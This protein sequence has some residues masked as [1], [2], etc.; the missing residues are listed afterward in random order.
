[1]RSIVIEAGVSGVLAL[2]QL[3]SWGLNQDVLEGISESDKNLLTLGRVINEE[4]GGY[5][6]VTKYGVK[7]AKVSGKY[8]FACLVDTDYPTVGDWVLC[9][10]EDALLIDRLVDRT[11]LFC[12]RKSGTSNESQSIAANLDIVFIVTSVNSDFNL[13]R[14]E[15]YL[16]LVR[17]GG[18][19]PVIVLNKSD[20][21]VAQDSLTALAKVAPGVLT[22]SVSGLTGENMTQMLEVVSGGKTAALVGSSGVGKS[23]IL[24][25]LLGK[26]TQQVQDIRSED[27]RGRHTTTSRSMFLLPGGGILIDT[28]GVREVGMTDGEEGVKETFADL[29]LMALDCRFSNCGHESEPGCAILA[30]IEAGSLDLNRLKSWRKLQRERFRHEVSQDVR[31]LSDVKRQRRLSARRLRASNKKGIY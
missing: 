27:D 25:Q 14:I 11:T 20:L 12:R 29:D 30:A 16:A 10:G 1:M 9:F 21:G 3:L 19:S 7:S 2:Q 4:K 28:P 6:V 23:T 18:I 8:Q 13:R 26:S 31:L 17:N 5:K 24:N 22:I 15:R